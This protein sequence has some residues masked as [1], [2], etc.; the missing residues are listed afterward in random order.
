MNMLRKRGVSAVLA[1]ALA[2]AGLTTLGASTASAV[3]IPQPTARMADQVAIVGDGGADAPN[4][5]AYC[6]R[7]GIT[8]SSAGSSG[9]PASSDW[10]GSSG[11]AYGAHGYS[12][13]CPT[14]L[15]TSQQ[16]ALGFT[17]RALTAITPETAFTSVRCGTSMVQSPP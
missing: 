4:Q 10:V 13:N 11:T 15:D 1:L 8:G 16:S 14:N 5:A 2:F 9:L 6:L 17:P 3:T 12:N 7:V